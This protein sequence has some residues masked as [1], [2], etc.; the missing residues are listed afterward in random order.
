MVTI[1]GGQNMNK[2]ILLRSA[3]ILAIITAMFHAISGDSILRAL[4]LP[5][6]ELTFVRATYQLGSMGWLAGGVLLIAAA[7]MTSQFAKNWII[8]VLAFVYGL[9][10]IGNFALNG[11]K[12]SFGWIALS[13]VVVLALLGRVQ[14][15]PLN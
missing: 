12:P 5:E 13:V 11:G 10:A 1:E 7:S 14:R 6:F 8:A 4:E 2:N 3:G 9:P 15:K